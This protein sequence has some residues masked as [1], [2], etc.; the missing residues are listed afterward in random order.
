MKVTWLG[1]TIAKSHIPVV[2]AEY[3]HIISKAVIGKD[4]DWKQYIN[5]DSVVPFQYF[6][7]KISYYCSITPK[8]RENLLCLT[9]KRVI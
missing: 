5:Y 2:C 8:W 1:D 3:D 9:S 6:S 7:F 4:E